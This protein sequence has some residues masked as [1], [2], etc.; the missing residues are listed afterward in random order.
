[1]DCLKFACSRYG[2][3]LHQV[4]AEHSLEDNKRAEERKRHLEE[5][6]KWTIPYRHCVKDDF[7]APWHELP[8]ANGLYMKSTRGYPLRA[9]AF[10]R[11]GYQV[12]N[13]GKFYNV[14]SRA[15]CQ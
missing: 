1:M 6:A 4:L 3:K 8:A 11:A 13:G 7:D 9:A 5:V 15:A 14:S 12:K 2:P 10:P